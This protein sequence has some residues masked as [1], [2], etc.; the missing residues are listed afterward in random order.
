MGQSA[1]LPAASCFSAVAITVPGLTDIAFCAWVAQAE[2]GDRLEY[3]RGVLAVDRLK[4]IS[5]LGERERKRVEQLAS[6][7]LRAAE[8]GLVH[9]VQTRIAPDRFRYLAV[10]RPHHMGAAQTIQTLI[11]EEATA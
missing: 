8:E 4:V 5:A 1:R 6:R 10:A 9:L 3:H 11:T 7:A 2:P